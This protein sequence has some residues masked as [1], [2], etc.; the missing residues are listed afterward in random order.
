MSDSAGSVRIKNST[1]TLIDPATSTKQDAQ[2]TLLGAVT[3][4]ATATDTASSGLNGRLQRIAQRL[5]SIIALLAGGLPAALSSNGGVK[6]GLVDALPAGTNRIGGAYM[7]SGQ[8][9]D[10][11]GTV[12]TVKRAFA[13]VAAS[14]TDSSIIAAV[15]SKKLRVL[16]VFALTGGTATNV[17]F[18]SKPGGAGTAISP[19]LAN[20]VNGGEV[21][22]FNPFG[23][24]ETASGEGLTVTTGAGSATGILVG[25]VE[26]A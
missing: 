11:N 25:Y 16:F 22:P 21:L 10:E 18:N 1:G 4:T 20:A 19:L 26:V 17:T 24:F 7:V 8:L 15:T 23:W 13:N 14:Q 3:E 12:L 5:T 6:A 9:I 2:S